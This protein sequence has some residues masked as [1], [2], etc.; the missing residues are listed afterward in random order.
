MKM[1]PAMLLMERDTFWG[2]LRAQ[3]L[4]WSHLLGLMLFVVVACGLYGAVLAGWRS[5]RLA[6]YVALKLPILFLGTAALVAIF[7]WMTATALG[8]GLSFKSTLFVVMASLTIA[9]WIL[10]SLVPVALFF[11]LSA[12]SYSGTP[13]ELQVAHNVILLTHISILALAGLG[14][15]WVLLTGLRQTV[16]ST[17]PASVLFALWISAFAFVGGQLSWILRPFVGSPFFPVAFMRPDCLERNFY[18]FIFSEVLPFLLMGG[19]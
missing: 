11:L 4:R 15:N 7:N 13:A 19:T 9:A 16:R 14:G 18:E 3:E 10:L 2:R 12:V 5:P 8:S 17:C 6:L 1:L